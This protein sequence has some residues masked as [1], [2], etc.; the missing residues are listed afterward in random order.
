M[1]QLYSL[2][3]CLFLFACSDSNDT[4]PNNT[5]QPPVYP[6]AL[7]VAEDL[8]STIVNMDPNLNITGSVQISTASYD[9]DIFGI[10]LC[11]GDMINP[12]ITVGAGENI[13]GCI[14]NVS[15]D[16]NLVGNT[17]QLTVDIPH[18]EVGI[19]INNDLAIVE[20]I[21]QGLNFR[22]D[23]PV[24]LNADGSYAVDPN[25]SA[26]L[27]GLD[28]VGLDMIYETADNTLGFALS[29]TNL[30]LNILA[31]EIE[32]YVEVPLLPLID[33]VMADYGNITI[34]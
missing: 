27:V 18:A 16:A 1:K 8:R 23:I 15:I 20:L 32:P 21:V 26:A 5:N 2:A 11:D 10:S 9:L 3:L 29:A 4:N 13:F 6:T 25:Y 31:P 17:L 33:D 12:P 19:S 28:W 14:P 24:T 34:Q 22:L 30:V 7:E